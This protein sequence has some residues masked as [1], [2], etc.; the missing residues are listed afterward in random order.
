[1]LGKLIK[2]EFRQTANSVIAVYCSALAA[3]GFM[4]LS[5]ITDIT[6]VGALGSVALVFIGGL[7]IVMTMVAVISN[8]HRSL[9]GNQGYLTFTLPVKCGDLLLSKFLVSAIWIL[10]SYLSLIA[11]I[12]IVY[13]YAKIKSNGIADG[14]TSMMGDFELISQLPSK[15]LVFE[16]LFY[17]AIGA[18]LNIITFIGYVYF[19][20]TIANTRPLQKHP[21]MFGIITFIA[22]YSV[23]QA[24]SAKLTYSLPLSV[25]V[26]SDSVRLGF[27][28]M[29]EAY[30]Q[31][32]LFSVGA[33]GTIFSAIVAITLLV[34]TGWI[35][36]NKV[37]IK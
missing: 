13:F 12:V 27:V 26:G 23:V 7:C 2:H 37:N 35:M 21:L 30:S 24:I 5:Y 4:L 28:S 22:S 14:L 25:L 9:Y 19:A 36:E 20:V 3:M 1:M 32:A 29:Q 15:A 10:I 8:F 31:G 34:L 18:F 17:I 6:W 11:C 33:G 16:F